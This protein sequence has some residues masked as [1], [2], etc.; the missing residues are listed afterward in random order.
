VRGRPTKAPPGVPPTIS[1]VAQRITYNILVMPKGSGHYVTAG[2]K[3]MPEAANPDT[4]IDVAFAG[5]TIRGRIAQIYIPPG[6]D[7]HCI[8][9]L[10]V[11][12]A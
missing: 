9:T 8:G 1:T 12:E 7:E 2:Q 4:E 6:C 11:R 3:A 5:R 10:F